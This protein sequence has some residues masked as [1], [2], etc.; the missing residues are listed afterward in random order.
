MAT[1]NLKGNPFKLAGKLPEVGDAA[2]EVSLAGAD[3]S[4]KK[5]GGAQGKTQILVVVP[6][7]DT[8]VCA[9]ETRKF[10]ESAAAVPGAEITV[11][12]MDLPF[13][14]KRFCAA[15]GIK[16]VST[17]SDFRRKEFA[18][19]YGVLIAEGPLEGL[20]CRAIFIVGKDGRLAYKQLVPE[21]SQEP[22]YAAALAAA[23]SVPV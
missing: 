10:N 21:V 22:D 19:A 13:A 14:A 12:S 15:E 23:D 11:I 3:L 7:V 4:E 20:T 5:V 17:A 18:K 9:T 8:P 16:N 2:P 1:V 6:S